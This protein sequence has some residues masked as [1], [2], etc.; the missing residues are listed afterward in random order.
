MANRY[1]DNQILNPLAL[2]IL[3]FKRLSG[4]PPELIL[5]ANPLDLMVVGPLCSDPMDG[6]CSS[7][8][9]LFLL[10]GL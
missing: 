10:S 7:L 4:I 2:L 6:I 5:L 3:S 8:V 9:H 1:S